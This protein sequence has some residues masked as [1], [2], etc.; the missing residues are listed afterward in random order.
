MNFKKNAVSS[1]KKPLFS[2][3]GNDYMVQAPKKSVSLFTLVL[4]I[5]CTFVLA[6]L[7]FRNYDSITNFFSARIEST[8]G[9]QIGQAIS[10]S[11][12]LKANGDLISYSHTL[13]LSDTTVVGIK[14]RTLDLSL[15]TGNIDIQ[16]T[17]EKE[18]N[19]I[20]IIEVSVVSGSLA[21]TGSSQQVLLGSGSGIYISQAGIYLPA[22][23][24]TKYVLLNQGE[25]GVLRV[26]NII[27]NQILVIGYF[28]C[29]KTDPNKDC[30]QLQ[31]NIGPSAEKVVPISYENKLYKLEGVSSWFF[32]NGN[33]YGYFIND[34]PEQEAIDLANAFILPN[35]SYVTNVLLSKI[36]SLCTDGNT[37]LTQVTTSSLGMDLNGLIINI[38]GPT[39]DGSA[40]CKVFIDP[41]QALGGTKISYVSSTPTVAS[42]T[43]TPPLPNVPP[44]TTT[45]TATI[46]TSVKQFPINLEKAITFT[47]NRGYSLVFPSSNIAYESIT[48]DEDL[49]LPGVRCS[50]QMN[51][52]KFSDK[53][54]MSDSPKVRVFAC[55]IK[56]TLSDV[57]NSILQKTSINGIQFLIQIMDP[58][59]AEFAA[60]IQIN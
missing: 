56:G 13:T 8:T 25:N 52:T 10:L 60:N 38:Q 57:G 41:S 47:S 32:T 54:T 27:T 17:V 33:Y 48:T 19:S 24:G 40:T 21:S 51:V 30:A 11:G 45:P 39:S 26:Q 20:Y 16:G 35:Q 37:S 28:A 2:G 55:T 29:R 12:I 14:S 58:A 6:F 5:V 18:L 49:G 4:V 36:Q 1:V 59:W 42:G 43:D 53:A 34:V 46:D 9:F 31:K 22:E 7:L 50:S 23:F 15:Y 44:T 3:H